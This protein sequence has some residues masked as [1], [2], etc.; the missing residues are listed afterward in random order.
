M[1]AARSTFG[2]T[3]AS[4]RWWV[5][6][7]VLF[8][9]TVLTYRRA[10]RAPD[11]AARFGGPA[12]GTTY[13]VVLGGPRTVAAVRGLQV[14][15]DSLLA[16]I[17]AQ[18]STYDT[19][20]E[21][22]RLNRDQRGI[23]YEVSAPLA[24]VLRE[25]ETISRASQGAFDVTVG[26]LVNAW[27]FGAGDDTAASDGDRVPSESELTALRAR[28]G[29]PQLVIDSARR[30]GVTITTV[31]K[32]HPQ[33]AVDLS[34]IAPGFTVDRISALLSSRGEADHFVELGGEVRAQGQASARRP[35][36]VGIESP[37]ATSGDEG[38]KPQS[39]VQLVVN[40]D[41]RALATSG[42]YRNYRVV[43]GVRYVHTID[44]ATGRPVQHRLLSVSV[45][46]TRCSAADAWATALLV[47]GPERAWALAREHRLDVLLLIA[48][49]PDEVEERMTPGFAAQ[50][51][52]R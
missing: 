46:H 22:S 30:G 18:M 27:G 20:S 43:D 47:V 21:L 12:Q 44:P 6:L 9:A 45:L 2:I 38:G 23:P 4:R 14:A 11:V 3:Q 32:R 41:N 31:T 17:D 13:A 16:E 24:A 10:G 8:G 35:F 25:A 36:R 28:V 7:A 50:V 39:R 40:L 34:G 37:I 52:S 51:V 49:A 5:V 33:L 29:W 42:N 1:T 48:G 15:V 19:T 26:P